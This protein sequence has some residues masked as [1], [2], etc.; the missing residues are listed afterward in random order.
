VLDARV[1]D[2]DDLARAVE[3]LQRPA[4][5]AED[6][7]VARTVARA[8][9]AHAVVEVELVLLLRRD[10][11]HALDRAD[12]LERGGGN[13]QTERVD[14]EAEAVG[15]PEEPLPEPHG[16]LGHVVLDAER[17]QLA[18]EVLLRAPDPALDR[19]TIEGLPAA[20]GLVHG[21]GRGWSRAQLH[22]D[23]H[24]FC[25]SSGDAALRREREGRGQ[26]EGDESR[27]TA[28]PQRHG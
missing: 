21:H 2:R 26:D 1:Q 5:L 17:A 3:A 23:A 12:L 13:G 14:Q 10:A 19:V 25:A 9:V 18:Q 24:A 7:L 20:P 16:R 28:R 4:A 27:G 6:R 22:D 8:D 11:L 15:L